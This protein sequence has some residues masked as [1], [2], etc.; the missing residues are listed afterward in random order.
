MYKIIFIILRRV[1]NMVTEND[2]V[3]C[4]E[5]L[6][7]DI[8]NK[9]EQEVSTTPMERRHIAGIYATEE[10]ASEWIR[11]NTE[12][13]EKNVPDFEEFDVFCYYLI[14]HV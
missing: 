7:H 4:V 6:T 13:Y 9:T 5:M 10:E 14:H 2:R 11:N 8:D 12:W 3:W 1:K